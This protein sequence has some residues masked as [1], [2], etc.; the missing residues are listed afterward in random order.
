MR[1]AGVLHESIVD[2]PGVRF[3]VF[4][5]G[6]PHRCPGCHNPETWHPAKGEEWSVRDLFRIIRKLPDSVQGLT[7]SG[8]EPFQQAGEMADLAELARKRGMSITTYTGYVYDDVLELAAKDPQAARLLEATD[9][10]VDGPY[11]EKLRDIGL[12]FRGSANQRVIDMNASRGA[13][14]M[15]LLPEG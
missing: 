8:G 9:I 6:C 4:A 7:L 1:I 10:L 15:V 2:G 3:V 14:A 5:Q 13:G 12:R 11:V